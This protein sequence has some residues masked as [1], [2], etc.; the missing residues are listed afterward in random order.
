MPTHIA[1]AT[2]QTIR[3][4]QT[5]VKSFV[6]PCIVSPSRYDV[7][8]LSGVRGE[9]IM[10]SSSG[11]LVDVL[12]LEKTACVGLSKKYGYLL[13]GTG[14]SILS[15]KRNIVLVWYFPNILKLSLPFPKRRH[16]SFKLGSR[17]LRW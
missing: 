2:D 16:L 1:S 12:F 14:L 6:S 13:R 9:R 4:H 17:H 5:P 10:S 3:S 11:G 7:R 15:S 8:M